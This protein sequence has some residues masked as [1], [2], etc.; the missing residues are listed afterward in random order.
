MDK[1]NKNA[2]RG[3]CHEQW[4]KTRL[5]DASD[6]LSQAFFPG[7]LATGRH[8]DGRT[9]KT[10]IC[11]DGF[12]ISAKLAKGNGSLNQIDRSWAVKMLGIR[13]NPKGAASIGRMLG[14]FD[15]LE[16]LERDGIVPPS[17]WEQTEREY[18]F[19]LIEA[20]KRHLVSKAIGVQAG[21]THVFVSF[22]GLSDGTDVHACMDS[23]SFS[24]WLSEADGA[25][26]WVSLS[27]RGT[28][29]Y[30]GRGLVFKR[31]GGDGGAK[32]AN[33]AQLS[34]RMPRLF[35]AIVAGEIRDARY[36]IEGSTA[37]LA[38]ISSGAD[39]GWEPRPETSVGSCASH[40]SDPTPFWT[41]TGPAAGLTACR[42]T[43][44]SPSRWS[45]RT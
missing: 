34:L 16:L 12:A 35:A 7:M 30:L 23:G 4:I 5:S 45:T 13:G 15:G 17:E 32:G 8:S 18:A 25:A 31:K 26:G 38:A 24:K 10:D 22:C 14:S 40:W 41:S 6:P 37:T 1:E 2:K 43:I 28:A 21:V 20:R 44:S 9:G 11:G 29:L 36:W 33:Q 39:G 3:D 42:G 27:D 19:S